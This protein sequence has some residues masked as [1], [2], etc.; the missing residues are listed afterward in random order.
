MLP[1]IIPAEP[2]I[3]ALSVSDGVPRPL[4]NGQTRRWRSGLWFSLLKLWWTRDRASE[5]DRGKSRS[6]DCPGLKRKR[7]SHL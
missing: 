5:P 4:A 7:T 6:C 1:C 3:K 2:L